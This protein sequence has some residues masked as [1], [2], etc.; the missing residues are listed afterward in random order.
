MTLHDFDGERWLMVPHVEGRK[1]IFVILVRESDILISCFVFT[2]RQCG[3]DPD[4]RVFKKDLKI[5]AA[6]SDR[7]IV[8]TSLLSFFL[9]FLC[10]RPPR[11]MIAT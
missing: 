4:Q 3:E 9:S 6:L 5:P 11:S 1:T 2:L 8:P 10:S 7:L